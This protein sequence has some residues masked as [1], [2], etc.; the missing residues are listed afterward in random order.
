MKQDFEC[1]P[2]VDVSGLL[3]ATTDLTLNR[4][5]CIAPIWASE[6]KVSDGNDRMHSSVLFS[7]FTSVPSDIFLWFDIIGK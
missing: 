4:R 5:K 6:K 3:D 7:S 1:T 2:R